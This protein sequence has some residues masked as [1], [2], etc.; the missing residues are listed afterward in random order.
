MTDK[1]MN[2]KL[3]R[4]G[5]LVQP[6]F[7]ERSE[8]NRFQILPLIKTSLAPASPCRKLVG[9]ASTCFQGAQRVKQVL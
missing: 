8:S 3:P 9:L 5:E 2:E 4:F 6:V 1:A 7:K